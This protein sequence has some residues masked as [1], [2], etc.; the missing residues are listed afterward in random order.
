MRQLPN[1]PASNKTIIYTNEFT[2]L[3]HGL[4]I[5]DGEMAD[6]LNMSCDN[7][8]VLSTRKSRGKPNYSESGTMQT[9]YT[10]K[11][12][13]MLG[14]DHLVVCAGSKVYLDGKETPITLSAEGGKRE[15]KI[16][17]MGA[18]VCIWPDCK[19]F[20]VNNF[21][22][23]G[24]M[25]RSWSA[26]TGAEITATMCRKDGTDY[27]LTNI[28]ASDTPPGTPNNKD[29]WID[30]S[31][32]NSVLKQ[33]SDAHKEWVQVA[34]TYIKIQSP[35]IGKGLKEG[36][37][38]WLSGIALSSNSVE[39]HTK[40]FR[41]ARTTFD[42]MSTYRIMRKETAWLFSDP[43][44]GYML[45]TLLVEGIPENAVITK[46]ELVFHAG[47]LRE[48][49]QG[50]SNYPEI[51]TVNG[52]SFSENSFVR[53][54][55]KVTGNGSL[56]VNFEFKTNP[57]YTVEV[58][59]FADVI[60]ISNMALEVTYSIVDPTDYEE[61]R[62]ELERLNTTNKLYGCGDNYIIVAGLLKNVNELSD[63]LSVEMRIP[64][65]DYVC[66]SNNRIWGCKR[67][68]VDGT[69]VNEIRACALGDFRNWY[70]FDGTS[71]DSYTVSVGSDGAFTGAYS[72]QG[73]LLF[74]K[75]N[76]IHKISGTTPSNFTMNTIRGRGVQAGSWKS[77]AMVNE[78]LFYKSRTDIMAYEGAMP[79]AVSGK[80]GPDAYGNAV[81]GAYRDKYYISMQKESDLTW[82]NYVL[83]V[84]KGLWHHED[85]RRISNMASVGGELVF[86]MEES[87]K[88]ILRTAD[89]RSQ[90]VEKM[91][92][93]VTFG[94]M[95]FQSEQ[96]KYLS[97][98]NIRAQMS[99]GSYMKVEMQYDSDG[100]W[101]HMGTMKSP[102]LQTFLLPI[103]PRRCDHCQ[104]RISGNGT[105]NI[106]SV[107]REYENGGDG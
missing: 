4:S 59:T 8:P 2:G 56:N 85:L 63:Q 66:E 45:H 99:A 32:E 3:N 27:D 57:D 105:I 64:D 10:E 98:Y 76:F 60:T 80:L 48:G 29:Y 19:F 53:M 86:S 96:Q 84:V 61:D 15:K 43:V 31:G 106:Y 11:V 22:D 5:A 36:D 40:T 81:A 73:T 51:L 90:V 47:E 44:T 62:K 101:V 23:Y 41:P 100:K 38:V 58:G 55:V 25:G 89:S 14:T 91:D 87:D 50:A 79:Y 69:V 18:Y 104:L 13:G 54:P 107:A 42:L 68:E 33:Y 28:V 65:F 67:S 88:T 16:V 30:T 77:L 39:S 102:Q 37:V 78:T 75:E 6:M 7:Y 72:M 34:T 24:D 35:G 49:L 70:R 20:H 12:N 97:R 83:D 17:S 21:D 52:V 92:W 103:I 74:F 1:L 94:V 82:H 71:M 26:A 93:M 95:G 9:E 46:S